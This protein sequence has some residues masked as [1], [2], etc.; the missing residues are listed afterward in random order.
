MANDTRNKRN[1][2][3]QG[4]RSDA[5]LLDDT[6]DGMSSLAGNPDDRR[7]FVGNPDDR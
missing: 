3:S 5:A 2:K 4:R 7:G 1:A 6:L